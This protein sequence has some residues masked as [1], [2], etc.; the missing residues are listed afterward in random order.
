MD[1]VDFS[2]EAAEA[3]LRHILDEADLR[4][5]DTVEHLKAGGITCIWWEERAVVIVEE[6]DDEDHA[7]AGA[8]AAGAGGATGACMRWPGCTP[9]LSAASVRRRVLI[10]LPGAG[11]AAA[12]CCV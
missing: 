9:A 6:G 12:G 3:R 7:D 10:C 5:P 8:G 4:Q 11:V 1:S 2:P